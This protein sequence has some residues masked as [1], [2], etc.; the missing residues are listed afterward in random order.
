[1]TET[2]KA[3]WR[4]WNWLQHPQSRAGQIVGEGSNCEVQPCKDKQQITH[5]PH[6]MRHGLGLAMKRI[7]EDLL[8]EYSNSLQ[9]KE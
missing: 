6:N 3:Q 8:D 1:M 9:E 7:T 2:H 4:D 5:P